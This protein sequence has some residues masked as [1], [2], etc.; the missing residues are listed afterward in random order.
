M[1]KATPLSALI[2][3]LTALAR[4][5]GLNDAQWCRAAGVRK[6]TLSRLRSRENCDVATL[7]VL[8]SAVGARIA[9]AGGEAVETTADGHFPERIDRYYE[10]R[11]IDL[12]AASPA[13]PAAWRAAGPAF[14]VAGL[15]V[16][17]ASAREF[18]RHRM[19]EVAEALHPGSSEPEVFSL[20]LERSPVRPS[21]LLPMVRQRLRHAA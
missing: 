11:L 1:Q 9:V 13:D 12:V 17:A 4:H 18:D 8:A 14:F 15:A 21:R 10:D 7:I 6:E 3:D 5:R 16:M 2:D 19:L 20:W